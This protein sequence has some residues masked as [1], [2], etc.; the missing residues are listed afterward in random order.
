MSNRVSVVRE[1]QECWCPGTRWSR[2]R[3]PTLSAVCTSHFQHRPATVQALCY[4]LRLTYYAVIIRR[5][6]Y[7]GP[8]T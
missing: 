7:T 4:F 6:S 1:V 5:Q 8:P 2:D 3:H